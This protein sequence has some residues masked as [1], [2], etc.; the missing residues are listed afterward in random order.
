MK[1]ENS[2]IPSNTH[3][4]NESSYKRRKHIP[5]AFGCLNCLPDEDKTEYELLLPTRIIGVDKYFS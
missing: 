5:N 2:E 4:F 1:R 3:S